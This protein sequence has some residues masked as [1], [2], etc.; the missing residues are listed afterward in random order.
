MKANSNEIKIKSVEYD[1]SFGELKVQPD[2]ELIVKFC[3]DGNH[4]NVCIEYESNEEAQRRRMTLRKWVMQS[5]YANDYYLRVRGN[6]VY[7]IRES[8][9]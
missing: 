6:K 3:E 2:L 1:V 8:E 5:K 4:K 9:E 7:V